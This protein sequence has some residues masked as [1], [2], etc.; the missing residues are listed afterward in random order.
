[1]QRDL[2]ACARYEVSARG[3]LLLLTRPKR[4]AEYVFS[5]GLTSDSYPVTLRP[6]ATSVVCATPPETTK[7]SPTP[8]T[9][10]G[11]V[12]F[13]LWNYGTF[14]VPPSTWTLDSSNTTRARVPRLFRTLSVVPSLPPRDTSLD[15]SR[16]P[17]VESAKSRP[18]CWTL[19]VYPGAGAPRGSP[20]ARLPA[21]RHSA[22]ARR[23]PARPTARV[24]DAGLA[25]DLEKKTK[26]GRS[27]VGR[28]RLRVFFVEKARV[29][30]IRSRSRGG[31]AGRPGREELVAAPVDADVGP[32]DLRA[33]TF[34]CADTQSVCRYFGYTEIYIYLPGRCAGPCRR[35][36]RRRRGRR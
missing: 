35:L 18:V 19:D 22:A 2:R 3:I 6:A 15:H 1:M 4:D 29:E 34:R 20:L 17:H 21:A 33:L 27:Y 32:K 31:F 5:K 9:Q 16:K 11:D 24:S 12:R 36:C 23:R 8:N 7:T 30:E 26:H 10:V 14:P 28:E 25:H 13:V